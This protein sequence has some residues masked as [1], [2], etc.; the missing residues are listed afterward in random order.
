MRRG[1]SRRDNDERLGSLNGRWKMQ[2][3]RSTGNQRRRNAKA[4]IARAILPD[5]ETTD[6]QRAGSRETFISPRYADVA[7]R[8]LHSVCRSNLLTLISVAAAVFLLILVAQVRARARTRGKSEVKLRASTK[9]L[10]RD[11]S[12]IFWHYVV[13]PTMYQDSGMK[14]LSSSTYK[15]L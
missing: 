11:N 2:R 3:I 1:G 8:R 5:L 10:S 4:R 6:K 14:R 12:V 15:R 13:I 7:F 9:N